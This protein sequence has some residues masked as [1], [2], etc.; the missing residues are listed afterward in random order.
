MTDRPGLDF[1]FSGLKTFTA[2]TLAAS[3]HEQ[4]TL[5]DIA[6]AF[7]DAVVDTL[8]IKC[9]RALQ[10][11]GYKRLVIAGGVSANKHLREQLAALMIKAVGEVF[12]PRTEFC[13]DN[14][15]MI[16]LAGALRLQAGE[17][18]PLAIKTFP[19]WPMTDL[20]P[21]RLLV[22]SIPAPFE[23]RLGTA[24]EAQN[25]GLMAPDNQYRNHDHR[26]GVLG[27][28]PIRIKWRQTYSNQRRE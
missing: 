10:Q 13:T 27:L 26:N 20:S 5:A 14:G 22:S 9:R 19:R 11:T 18:Q 1:S 17:R 25:I 28:Y 3:D 23:R 21:M 15:A 8:V 12:Y 24:A 16:A 2:N 7:E 6:Q 4:Q